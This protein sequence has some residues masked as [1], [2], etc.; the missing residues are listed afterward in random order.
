[1]HGRVEILDNLSKIGYYLFIYLLTYLLTATRQFFGQN[2]ELE[3]GLEL[4]L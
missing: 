4:G 2:V 1:M 3:W